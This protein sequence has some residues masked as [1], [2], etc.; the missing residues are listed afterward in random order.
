M[1]KEQIAT[2]IISII[3]YFLCVAGTFIYA[4]RGDI[5]ATASCI[6]IAEMWQMAITL[7]VAGYI[8]EQVKKEI[9]EK[10]SK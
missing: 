6:I 8:T 9:T 4:T 10:N 3:M 5:L 1:K 2:I 7:W